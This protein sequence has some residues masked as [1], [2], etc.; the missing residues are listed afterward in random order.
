MFSE[1]PLIISSEQ[2]NNYEDPSSQRPKSFK[3][4]VLI[5][6]LC[7]AVIIFILSLVFI[8]KKYRD[9]KIEQIVETV[10]VERDTSTGALPGNEDPNGDIS[11]TSSVMTDTAIEYLTFTDFYEAP[12]NEITVNML[13]YEL[14]LNIKIDGLNYYDLSRKLNL[15]AA[16]SSLNEK[17][18]ATLAN[19][20]QAQVNDFYSV[21][22]QLEE[23]QLPFLITSDFIVYYYQNMLK[24]VFKEIEANIFYQNFW[25]INK[26]LYEIAKNRYEMRL[27]SIGNVNDAILEG[28]RMEMAFFAVTLELLKPKVD[29]VAIK[30]AIED[31][32]KF[33][34]GELERFY[35]NAPLYLRD[36]V[37]KEV[38]LIKAG[39]ENTKSP[40]LIYVRNYQDFIVPKEYKVDAK[41]NNFYLATKWVNSV[42]PLNYKDE[43]C[44]DCL[45]D[46]EDWRLSM[47]AASFISQDLSNQPEL[48]NRWARIYKLMGFFQGL[49]EEIN[50]VDFRDS[51][52]NVFGDDYEIEALFSDRNPEAMENLEKIK[53]KIS[54]KEYPAI[55]GSLDTSN[56]QIKKLIG[57]KML[58][59]YYWPNEYIFNNLSWPKVS[60]YE[61]LATDDN[62]LTSCV[63]AT[64]RSLIRCTG[65]SLDIVNLITPMDNNPVFKAN[66]YYSNYQEASNQLKTTFNRDGLW[67]TSNYW[68]TLILMQSIVESN[69]KGLPNFTKSDAWYQKNVESAV[70]AWVNLQLPLE[71]L[72]LT[73]VFKGNSLSDFGRYGNDVY[74]EPNLPLINELI[75]ANNMLADMFEALSIN[76]EINLASQNIKAI[77]NDLYILQK[78][79]IKELSGE[80]L[81]E[82]DS[83]AITEFALK[84]MLDQKREDRDKI[85]I[86]NSSSNKASIKQN[87]NKLKLLV[88]VHQSGDNKVL[89]V[90]PIWDHEEY[91]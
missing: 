79:I 41:L 13:D 63:G 9:N 30:G 42:F 72:S 70:S 50:Y 5:V 52:V 89:S 12:N 58:A 78:I 40:N 22:Q 74:V 31:E 23:K 51:L 18:F 11:A 35:F 65:F 71:K 2:E 66:S 60:S 67:H 32:T 57:F 49:R 4:V 38:E 24:K 48:K 81:N 80:D 28:Q 29:Q 21:Y 55:R 43:S 53:N 34:E 20:W 64:S 25:L 54:T 87:L 76:Q 3:K 59:D 86:L 16:I 82:K 62:S 83:E 33:N 68:S 69:I 73:P 27:A 84:Y 91:R 77:D 26:E 17:G 56:T 10:E 75:A 88:L 46:Q 37:L 47:I 36:D 85:L 14:P 45:L 44:P 90:G 7:L 1:Q 19:P 8:I 61:G 39:K 6:G 15:D